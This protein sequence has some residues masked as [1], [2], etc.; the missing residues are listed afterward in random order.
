MNDSPDNTPYDPWPLGQTGIT[1]AVRPSVEPR[2][3]EKVSF[4]S[5]PVNPAFLQNVIFIGSEVKREFVAE[6]GVPERNKPQK[7][8]KAGLPVWTVKLQAQSTE[9]D[10]RSARDGAIKINLAAERD[11]GEVFVFGQPVQIV[12]PWFGVTP[13][14]QGSAFAI[15]WAAEAIRPAQHVKQSAA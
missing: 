8:N 10:G 12:N 7:R 13:I 9:M 3:A 15:W 2:R 6:K 5:V 4:D 1:T 14:R 11:P